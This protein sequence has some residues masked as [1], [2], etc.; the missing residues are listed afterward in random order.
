MS[1]LNLN[2]LPQGGLL[3][4]GAGGG[5]Q[6][7]FNFAGLS[8]DKLRSLGLLDQF[9]PPPSPIS[10]P[11]QQP[12]FGAPN[13]GAQFL[14]QTGVNFL[15]A[16][17]NIL[18][19]EAAKFSGGLFVH[20]TSPIVPPPPPPV[21]PPDPA[22]PNA[23]GGGDGNT[24]G[25]GNGSDGTNTSGN[26]GSAGSDPLGGSA[27]NNDSGAYGGERA[28]G[29]FAQGD[30]FSNAAHNIGNALGT[31]GGLATG[32]PLGGTIGATIGDAIAG[33]N[34]S[35]TNNIEAPGIGGLL[36]AGLNNLTSFGPI[37][38]LLG[39]SMKN[40]ITDKMLEAGLYGPSISPEDDVGTQS[41]G[42]TDGDR[43]QTAEEHAN[44]AAQDQAEGQGNRDAAA[45]AEG[46]S[47]DSGSD[48]SAGGDGSDSGGG[49]DGHD[50]GDGGGYATG[51]L[52]KGQLLYGNRRPG[53]K[54]G[55]LMKGPGTSTSDSI[56]IDVSK[57]E[58]V[59][60]TE[61]TSRFGP[62]FFGGLKAMA[63]GNN[64]EA[65]RLLGPATFMALQKGSKPVGKLITK[66][67]AR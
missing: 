21:I 42:V 3:G 20:G 45:A 32:A 39:E 2:N 15:D 64:G 7:P 10:A 59:N 67:P 38:G 27:T 52:V 35:K 50:S 14:N 43:Q 31:V 47:A 65:V 8:P 1:I 17:G 58:Y 55:G 19:P 34:F 6:L 4:G 63:H 12:G 30:R 29:S 40:Q 37:G 33:N 16:K 66:R 44:Q 5:P 18:S 57:G 62:E 25:A 61:T 23:G 36:S 28:N 9:G 24:G 49:S 56:P 41:S 54:S 11:L 48:S 46:E 22:D 51:G 53:K 26:T 13:P 60:D